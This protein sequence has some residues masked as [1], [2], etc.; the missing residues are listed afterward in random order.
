M[1]PAML[2]VIAVVA[3][4]VTS[5]FCSLSEASLLSLSRARAEVLAEKSLAGRIIKRLKSDMERPIAAI[6]LVNTVANT[7]GAAVAGSE[8]RNIF[9][10]H[11]L[12]AFSAA[13]TVAVLVFS[14]YIPKSL[15]VRYSERAATLVA[16][17]LAWMIAAVSPLTWLIDRGTK[18]FAGGPARSSPVSIDD[19][20]ATARL[21][22]AGKLLGREEVAII[23]AAARLPRTP[24]KSI[25]VHRRDM[26]FFSLADDPD[27]NLVRARRSLHSRL[28]VCRKDLDE[29][30]GVVNMK[31]VLWRLAE[32]TEDLE[33][34]GFNRILGEQMRPALYAREDLDVGEL[35]QLFAANRGHLALVRDEAGHIVGMVTLEDVVEVLMGEVDDELDRTPAEIHQNADGSWKIGG[36]A[37][38]AEVR[39][40]LGLPADHEVDHDL[41]GRVDLHDVAAQHLPGKLRSGATFKVGGWSFKLG[42]IRRGKVVSVEA[43]SADPAPPAA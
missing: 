28:P 9:G 24:V 31:E 5:F 12:V 25:M 13:L 29:V 4:L 3:V 17:P 26:V 33:E 41:D 2:L 38:W 36:S 20:R 30:L 40:K 37:P 8:Y 43:R 1:G 23:E 22:A 19:V 7:G 39:P 21:A 16:R 18:L 42:R 10:D 34:E 35:I 32:D 27:T 14:E 6:L 11:T 15:G